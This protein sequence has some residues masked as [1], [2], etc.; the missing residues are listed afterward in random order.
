MLVL[1][2][3]FPSASQAEF[4]ACGQ[5]PQSFA[6][7][8]DD[9]SFDM[10]RDGMGSSESRSQKEPTSPNP[11]NHRKGQSPGDQV[12]DAAADSG[13]GGA[14]GPTVERS[15]SGGEALSSTGNMSLVVRASGMIS[16]RESLIPPTPIPL[17]ILDPP[18]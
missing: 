16:F 2:A 6:A 5:G 18:K 17:G 7:R 9:F 1:L 15:D 11:E 14:S 12:L 8:S 13:T 10:S 3:M 4:I